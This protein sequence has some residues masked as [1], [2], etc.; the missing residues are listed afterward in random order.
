[1]TESPDSI[2]VQRQLDLADLADVLR[3]TEAAI[4]MRLHR[5]PQTLPP[6]YRVGRAFRWSPLAVQNWIEKQTAEA[7]VERPV[8]TRPTQPI[9]HRRSRRMR[10]LSQSQALDG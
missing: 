5:N 7:T 9:R 2:G 3:T 4:R 6:F 1:M 10:N 8:F